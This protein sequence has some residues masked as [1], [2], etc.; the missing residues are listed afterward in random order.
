M[1]RRKIIWI[2]VIVAGLGIGVVLVC[3]VAANV[4]FQS[5]AVPTGAMAPAIYGEHV[6]YACTDCG[7][8]F[9]VGRDAGGPP[10]NGPACPNCGLTQAAGPHVLERG[11]RVLVGRFGA[12]TPGRWDIFVFRNP[13]EPVQNYVK[14][15]VGLPGETVELVGGNV[16]INGRVAQK[17]DAAQNELWMLVHDT[18]WRP[19]RAGWAPRWEAEKPWRPEGA[20]FA[21]DKPRKSDI[22]WLSYRHRGPGGNPQNILDSYGYNHSGSLGARASSE[23]VTDLCL[24][25]PVTLAAADAA[26]VVEL[27]ACKDRFRFELTSEGSPQPTCIYIN[28]KLAAKSPRGVLP[29]GRSAEVVAANV[30]HKLMLLVD[31][32]RVA[33]ETALEA[34]PEGDVTYEPAPLT[35]DER[36]R[37]DNPADGLPQSMAA[38]VRIGVRGGPATIEYLRLDRDVYY[39]NEQMFSHDGVTRPGHATEGNPFTLKEGEYFVLGDNSPR[40]FDSRLWDLPRPV[41]PQG[42]LIGKVS[43]IYRTGEGGRWI[44]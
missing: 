5:F 14:R 13:N 41:V 29:V 39:V 42:Y 24:R 4:V 43:F 32:R 20:G 36:D 25:A 40:S 15:I 37:F 11:D 26:A 7:C 27:R 21:L 2:I 8:P 33:T 28:G 34:T 44:K 16:T 30:D 10:A 9:G 23:V 12:K 17:P 1:R 38:E 6:K 22:A 35:A 19:T 31:G 18:R 3:A